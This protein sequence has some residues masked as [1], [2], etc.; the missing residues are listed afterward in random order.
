MHVVLAGELLHTWDGHTEG[1]NSVAISSDGSL[2]VSG[3]SDNTV[4]LWNRFS[5]M[6]SG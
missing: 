5:G 6:E 2:V 1:V 3:S 4:R